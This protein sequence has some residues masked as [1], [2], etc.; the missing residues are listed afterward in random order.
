MIDP[1]HGFF[2]TPAIPANW[3]P[4]TSIIKLHLNSTF[5]M[6]NKER[7]E[8]KLQSSID[9]WLLTLVDVPTSREPYLKVVPMSLVYLYLR[10]RCRCW[11]RCSC[12]R[13]FSFALHACG[14]SSFTVVNSP[15]VKPAKWNIHEFTKLAVKNPANTC[16]GIEL[17]TGK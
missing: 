9:A 2:D 11:S 6:K 10:S 5:S 15:A 7:I 12:G 13:W 3:T 4:G 16:K 1:Y 17:W 14:F 8:T